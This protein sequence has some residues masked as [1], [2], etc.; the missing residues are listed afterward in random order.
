MNMISRTICSDTIAS[1][2]IYRTSVNGNYAAELTDEGQGSP[3]LFFRYSERMPG[4]A[5]IP[6]ESTMV[7]QV[8]PNEMPCQYCKE[9]P[10]WKI[11]DQLPCMAQTG[12]MGT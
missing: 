8:I 11:I 9:L 1:C 12:I 7:V 4:Y 10:N 3:E 5:G 6:R 2:S